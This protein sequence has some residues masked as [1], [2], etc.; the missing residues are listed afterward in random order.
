MNTSGYG[1]VLAA[2]FVRY[3]LGLQTRTGWVVL[4]TLLASATGV[5][6]WTHADVIDILLVGSLIASVSILGATPTH[7]GQIPAAIS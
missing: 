1:W 2:A 6:A 3:G 7:T 4:G 5:L